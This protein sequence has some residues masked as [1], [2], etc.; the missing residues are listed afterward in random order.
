M[1]NHPTEYIRV[2][3]GR[4]DNIVKVLDTMDGHCRSGGNS[5]KMIVIFLIAYFFITTPDADADVYRYVSEDGVECYTNAPVNR[6]AVIMMRE[7]R[8]AKERKPSPA[9]IRS[10]AG[11]PSAPHTSMQGAGDSVKRALPVSGVIS[12]HV[13]LR[14]DPIDGLLRNHNGIDIAV[15]EGTPV[16]SVAPGIVTY[17]GSRNGYGNMVIVEHA[18][19]MVTIYAHNRTNLALAGEHVDTKSTIA[20]TGSTGRSTGPHLHFEAWQDGMN[21]TSEF[22]DGSTVSGRGYKVRSNGPK[23]DI[24]RRTVMADGTIL[25]TNLPLMHP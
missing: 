8:A 23:K 1:Q 4:T 7:H 15:P 9:S 2:K 20:L 11:T 14:Y 10:T 24:I 19:G 5:G 13:G 17:S 21:I 18:N 16:K 25:L 6:N 12:S 22:L 3:T